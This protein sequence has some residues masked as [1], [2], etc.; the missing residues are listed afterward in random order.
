M[1]DSKT[2]GAAKQQERPAER[3]MRSLLTLREGPLTEEAVG[4]IKKAV[5]GLGN[6]KAVRALNMLRWYALPPEV[7]ELAESERK[8]INP[9]LPKVPE[10]MENIGGWELSEA[11]EKMEVSKIRETPPPAMSELLEEIRSATAAL[12]KPLK[13]KREGGSQRRQRVLSDKLG[14]DPDC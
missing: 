11:F 9:E 3:I 13:R 4:M 7:K 2:K 6:E 14:D 5:T 12:E 1:P 10:G 8:R